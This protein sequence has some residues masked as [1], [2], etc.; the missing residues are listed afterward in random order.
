VITAAQLQ[1]WEGVPL[2][3]R[4]LRALRLTGTGVTAEDLSWLFRVRLD[5]VREALMWLR[6]CGVVE[7]CIGSWRA[8]R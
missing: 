1:L 2:A 8:I 7:E 4:V 6:D 3:E 5:D